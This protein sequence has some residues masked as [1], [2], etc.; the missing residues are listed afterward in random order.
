[1]TAPSCSTCTHHVAKKPGLRWMAGYCKHP[2][3][4]G[5]WEYVP[6]HKDMATAIGASFECWPGWK[7]YE[8]KEGI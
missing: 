1:M 7:L 4:S 8:A 3:Y 2:C 6:D 5:S